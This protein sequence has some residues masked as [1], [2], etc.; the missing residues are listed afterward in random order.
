MT[1]KASASEIEKIGRYRVTGEIGR[2]GMGVVYQA[3]DRLI[4]RLVAIKTLTEV[5]P[6]LR[7]RFYIEAKSGILN[8]PNIV[9]VYEVGEHEGNPFIVM[10]YVEGDSLEKIMREQRR[11]PLLESISIIEQLCTG[12]G[13]AHGHGVLHRDVKP[14]NILVRPDGRVTIVDFGIARLAD[15]TQQLT[16]TNTLLGTFHYI[17]PERL[18]GEES[19]G[20]ADIWSVGVIFYEMLTGEL[21]FKGSDISSLYRV[22][23]EPYVPPVEYVQNLPDGLIQVLDKALAKQVDVRYRSAED[24]ALDLHRLAEGM[25]SERVGALLETARRLTDESQYASARTVLLQV[26]RIDPG[27]TETKTR[28]SDVQDRLTQLHRSEQ[29]RLLIDQAKDAADGRRWNDAASLYEKAQSLDVENAFDL[30]GQL[31]QAQQAQQHQQKVLSLW[32]QA[33]E[34]HNLGDLKKAQDYLDQALQIDDHNTELRNAHSDLLQ[35]VK[36]KRQSKI[37]ELLRNAREAASKKQ[38]TE[39][40]SRLREAAEIDVANAEIQELMSSLAAQQKEGSLQSVQEQ[41]GSNNGAPPKRESLDSLDD[42]ATRVFEIVPEVQKEAS[43][44]QPLPKAKPSEPS[45]EPEKGSVDTQQK[46]PASRKEEQVGQEAQNT[47]LEQ[48]QVLLQTAVY[49]QAVKRPEGSVPEAAMF[50]QD[51]VKGQS[52][53]A[54]EHTEVF[55]V[56]PNVAPA[57]QQKQSQEVPAKGNAEEA[58][59]AE[60]RKALD[61]AVAECEKAI[62]AGKLD[63]CMR[64]LDDFAK[65]YGAVAALA[66][67]RGK[68]ESKREQKATQMLRAAIQ[69]AQRELKTNSPRKAETVLK[70]V[71][72]A[73]PFTVSD[74]RTE[75]Q[76]LR[77]ECT[78][79]L[80]VKPPKN[81]VHATRTKATWS[82]VSVAVLVAALVVAWL[83]YRRHAETSAPQNVAV[84]PASIQKSTVPAASSD[85]THM[86]INAS[87]WA[88]VIDIQDE[89]GNSVPLPGEDQT[90][91]LRLDGVKSGTYKVTFAAPDGKQQTVECNISSA[92]H[93][94]AADVGLPDTQQV[95]RGEQP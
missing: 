85:L 86:E 53:P 68:C 24:M 50:N 17:S 2:G 28:L 73:I 4:G 6:E 34:A 83:L 56:Q 75:W 42:H 31:Q 81:S 82:V 30:R 90:T 52:K 74:V 55:R 63:Q 8:H 47:K 7:E 35:E 25:K 13:Y 39:A 78:T 5:T 26:Q 84:V 76:K 10:E 95:L 69:T 88:K 48:T 49:T 80:S 45:K 92:E 79:A 29:L 46:M 22:I 12:L 15:Q 1:A 71:E 58:R 60:S 21:P 19:D 66:T 64:P 16:K 18:K 89:G 67:A 62:A 61:R 38:Y 41:A 70:G 65:Q 44:A 27:N 91:P 32:K 11:L 33:D 54:A 87:P 23:Y 3:E 59:A 51:Q 9:T 72:R 57:A 94:C 40:T 36:R 20:R 43:G 37:E 77:G 93:L 14:A